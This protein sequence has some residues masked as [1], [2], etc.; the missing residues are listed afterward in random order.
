M[1]LNKLIN[2]RKAAGDKNIPEL[3]KALTNAIE[4]K[5]SNL[6]GRSRSSRVGELGDLLF[7]VQNS[8]NFTGRSRIRNTIRENIREAAKNRNPERARD[9]LRRIESNLKLSSRFYRDRDI[10][11]TL[12][13]ERTFLRKRLRNNENNNRYGR[14]GNNNGYRRRPPPP[15]PPP[16]PMPRYNMEPEPPRMR[17]NGGSSGFRLPQNT[18]PLPPP[19]INLPPVNM[20]TQQ[21]LPPRMNQPPMALG[22]NAFAPSPSPVQVNL[23]PNERQ[24][25]NSIGGV[26]KAAN[27]INQGGGATNVAAAA[28]A[29]AQTGGNVN[30]AIVEKGADE[31]AVKVVIQLGGGK[32]ANNIE[33]A[34]NV[35]EG[36]NTIAATVRRKR[37]PSTA[38]KKKKKTV[39]AAKK[40]KTRVVYR[41]RPAD[42]VRTAELDK[43]LASVT[44][45][46]IERR[47]DNANLLNKVYTKEQLAKI[48]KKFVLG[49]NLAP[50]PKK[51]TA[52][53]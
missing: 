43:L 40:K 34:K 1:T 35:L 47:M 24:A 36:M 50:K 42:R 25:I 44:K 48:Y 41:T 31:K 14:G 27:I 29:L 3:N 17:Q 52:K 21:G 15:P 38:A 13:Q 7:R 26:N 45:N 16:P 28:N 46:T 32:N 10:K 9:E 23:P 53:K 4:R 18:I 51:K 37:R 6:R 22:G 2:A 33:K 20:G 5:I 39:G 8:R 12:N 11:E 49:K 30:R 19:R